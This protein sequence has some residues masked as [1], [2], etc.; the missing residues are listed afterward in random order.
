MYKL[1]N[2][3]HGSNIGSTSDVGFFTTNNLSDLSLVKAEKANVPLSIAA[4]G[5]CTLILPFDAEIPEGFE[6]YSCTGTEV[7]VGTSTALVLEKAESI[8]AHTPYIV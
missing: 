6:V 7:P 5:W 2:I 8:E 1:K 4:A 3:L